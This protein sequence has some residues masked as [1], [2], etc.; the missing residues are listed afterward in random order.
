MVMKLN[1]SYPATGLQKAIEI[2]DEKKLAMLYDKRLS[3]EITGDFLG[4][5]YKGYVFRISGGHDRQGF[6]MKQGVLADHRVR[7]LLKGGPCYRPRRSGERR[8][9][10]VR[11]C[12]ISHD[13]SALALVIVKKGENELAGLTD[14]NKP[15]RLGPKRASKIRKLFALSKKDDVRKYVIR[16]EVPVKDES[17]RKK[18]KTKAPKIQRLVTPVSLQRKR[19]LRAVRVKRLEKSKKL[20]SAYA[21]LIAKRK[22]EHAAKS[23]ASKL[24]SRLSRTSGDEKPSKASKTSDKA[25]PATEKK[26]EVTKKEEKKVEKKTGDKAEKKVEKKTGDKAEKKTGDKAEKK[27]DKK[28]EKKTDKKSDAKATGKDSKK[29]KD[30]KK[31]K[32]EAKPAAKEEAKPAAKE[33]KKPAGKGDKKAAAA[34]AKEEKKAAPAKE[35]KKAAAPAKEEKKPAPAKEEKKAAAPKEEKKAAAPAPAAAAP[36][37]AAAAPAPAKAAAAPKP[38]PADKGK[39][40]KQ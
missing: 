27:T 13:I 18:P 20:A 21:K 26:A 33:E 24:T 22:I 28:A 7:L 2:D 12:I 39:K 4:D 8:R 34:P 6:T 38:K 3:Q 15:R 19:H 25:T 1:I 5:E 23:R 31:P 16:R 32:E 37:P 9:K 17:K 35:E 14:G 30:D 11:G 40:G 36:A 10:S 29:A